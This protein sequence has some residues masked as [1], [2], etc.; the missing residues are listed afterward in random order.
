MYSMMI[1]VNNIVYFK[2]AKRVDLDNS[3]HL[4][5]YVTLYGD[6]WQLDLCWSFCN[7]CKY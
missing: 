3:H 4:K 1:K 2:V 6:R 7:V 5:K